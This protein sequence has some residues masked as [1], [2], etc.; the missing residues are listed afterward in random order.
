MQKTM[1]K[2]HAILA[3]SPNRAIGKDNDLPRDRI[4]GDLPRFKRLTMWQPVVMGRKTYES[5]GRPLPGR[6]N[7]VLSR[8]AATDDR[9]E[10]Y[11]SIN[12]I[13]DALKDITTA[14]VI[15]GAKIYE[16]FLPYIDDIYL[17]ITKDIY[18]WDVFLPAFESDFE[19]VSKEE[20]I[21][22]YF[23]HYTRVWNTNTSL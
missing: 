5:I 4:E 18:E 19:E 7:I 15:G 21:D 1:A 22:H 6:K 14:W 23:I 11:T 2:F 20:Y 17:T 12:D 3:M 9:I 13:R 8:T 16:L 10:R